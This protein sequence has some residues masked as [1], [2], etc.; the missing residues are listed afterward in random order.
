MQYNFRSIFFKTSLEIH[1]EM[2]FQIVRISRSKIH[3][4]FFEFLNYA[5]IVHAEAAFSQNRSSGHARLFRGVCE[6]EIVASALFD[7]MND[8]Y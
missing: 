2:R 7:Y 3:F 1:T 6:T 8:Y 5:V 4:L